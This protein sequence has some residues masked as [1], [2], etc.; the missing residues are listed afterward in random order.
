MDQFAEDQD[1]DNNMNISDSYF[2]DNKGHCV[3]KID[4][5]KNLID[6]VS[7]LYYFDVKG[8]SVFCKADFAYSNNEKIPELDFFKIDSSTV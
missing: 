7:Q 6:K 2:K 3:I 8:H 5:V 1:Q 4:N